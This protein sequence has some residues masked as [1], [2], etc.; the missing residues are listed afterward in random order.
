MQIAAIKA[1][2]ITEREFYERNKTEAKANRIRL[3]KDRPNRKRF[4]LRWWP[5]SRSQ[6]ARNKTKKSF[7]EQCRN[8]EQ[9]KNKPDL[10]NRN[11]K[12]Q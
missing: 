3:V 1:A 10:I 2:T 4:A 11:I 7:E 8:G 6:V 12:S 9:L 5:A